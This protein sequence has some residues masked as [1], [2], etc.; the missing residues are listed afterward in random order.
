MIQIVYGRATPEKMHQMAMNWDILKNQYLQAS[1][2]SQIDS[3]SLNLSWIQTLAASGVEESVAH[4]LVRE[5]QFFIEWSVPTINLETDMTFVT[6]LSTLQRQLSRW[7]LGWSDLWSSEL[8]RR[9]VADTAQRWCEQL[10][11]YLNAI[12]QSN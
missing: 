2:S 6:E 1:R 10:Q 12:A 8:E 5:S 9:Q 4:H 11:G 3:L 7:K